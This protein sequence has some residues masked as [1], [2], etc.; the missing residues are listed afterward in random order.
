MIRNT[1]QVIAD[2]KILISTK[3][4]IYS[5]CLILIDDFHVDLNKIHQLD[6]KSLLSVKECSLIIG[7]LIQKKID[8]GLPESPEKVVDLKDKTYEL[9]RELQ[10]SFLAPH[11]VKL[12]ELRK[13][14]DN[15][16]ILG[17]TREE[18]LDFFVKDSG[19]VEPMFYAGDGVYDFQY[20]EFL[21]SK[22]KY[23]RDWLREN[24]EFDIDSSRKIV[25]RIKEIR[26]RKI[27]DVAPIDVEEIFPALSK[28][29]RRKLK[30]EF[31][32]RQITEMERQRHVAATF[33]RYSLLF[34]DSEETKFDLT[35]KWVKFYENLLNIFIVTPTDLKDIDQDAVKAFFE[36]FSSVP[37]CNQNYEGF[38]YFNI[39]NSRPLVSLEDGRHFVGLNYLIPEA[40]YESPFYWMLEDENY[41]SILAKNRGEVGEEI[42][43]DF[44][45]RVFGID[46]TFRSVTIEA[47][48]GQRTTDIDVL[49]LLGNKALCVQV[50]SKK[51]TMTAKRGD[52]DQ[53]MKDFTGAVQ[54]AYHQGLISREAILTSAARFYDEKGNNFL[55]PRKV[56]D[57]YIM[58]LTTENYPSLA[59]Q[60]H[61]M[62]D[63]ED[64]D[65]YPL[66]VSVFDLELLVHYLKDP[67]DFLYYVRQ[68][69][70]LIEYFRGDEE[71]V[72]LGYHLDRKLWRLKDYDWVMLDT[73]FGALIDRNY[74]PHK[75]GMS[76][77]LPESD[78]PLHHRW[79]DPK[80]D[81]LIKEIKL[82]KHPKIVDIVFHLLDLSGNSRHEI[83][84]Q[85]A[86]IKQVSQRDKVT[87]SLAISS[88]PDFGLTYNVLNTKNNEDLE[89]SVITYAMLRKYRSKCDSWLGLGS[90][91]YSAN[92][93]DFLVFN[94]EVWKADADFENEYGETLSKMQET[95]VTSVGT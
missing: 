81:L 5:L 27:Q 67:F 35:E 28:K 77:L 90:F 39:L 78:D 10:T 30:K 15:G 93:V 91:S 37:G 63:K 86:M 7:F 92:F 72:Y 43:Y 23:D 21:E 36:N 70:D 11:A 68:R 88:F 50:K 44:L 94:D 58:G 51:L 33:F 6:Q 54:D 53:L 13:R 74:Y 16:E 69:I 60:V 34:P 64:K 80:F 31:S 52:F 48:K 62:L 95:P 3:G 83:V 45:V 24:R 59:H 42:A 29:E 87:K 61:M 2:L 1:E 9:M 76:H 89:D 4:Y 66:F 41:R 65:P 19:M 82:M 49:C 46:N 38:G 40:V 26:K 73:D 14:Q 12:Q 84:E 22:Y 55:L 56:D 71:L 57:V 20:L 32:N 17:N 25:A 75:I 85:M 47:K 18:R 8:F 79:K